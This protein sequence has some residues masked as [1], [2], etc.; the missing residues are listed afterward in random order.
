MGERKGTRVTEV[1]KFAV[2]VGRAR[3]EKVLAMFSVLLLE[4]WVGGEGIKR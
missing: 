2:V 1:R 4:E 3:E